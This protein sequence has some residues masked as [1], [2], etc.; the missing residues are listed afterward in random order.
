MK[1]RN[2]TVSRRFIKEINKQTLDKSHTH[3]IAQC[4]QLVLYRWIWRFV[5]TEKM[6]I[7]TLLHPYEGFVFDPWVLSVCQEFHGHSFLQIQFTIPTFCE[8]CSSIIWV[9]EKG[10]VCKGIFHQFICLFAVSSNLT[11][12][13]GFV[14]FSS[15]IIFVNVKFNN[16]S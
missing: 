5:N 16:W 7:I 10:Y 3:T 6:K 12:Y 15:L 14:Q 13:K 4:H 1:H 11:A 8:M 9:L 2:Q